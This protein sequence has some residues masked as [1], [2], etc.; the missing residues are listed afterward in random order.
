MRIRGVNETL[1]VLWEWHVIVVWR[2]FPGVF[3]GYTYDKIKGIVFICL[4]S[5]T[6][7]FLTF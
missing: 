2:T 4:H 1:D 3:K 5:D 6:Y 7:S